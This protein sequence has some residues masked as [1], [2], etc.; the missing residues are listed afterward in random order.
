[1]EVVLA[2]QQCDHYEEAKLE[3]EK[4]KNNLVEKWVGSTKLN[5]L[6]KLLWLNS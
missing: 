4:V 3:K 1:L 2:Q 6:L 5:T